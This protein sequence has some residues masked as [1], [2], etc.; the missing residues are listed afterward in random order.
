MFIKTFILKYFLN[1]SQIVLLPFFIKNQVVIIDYLFVVD[2]EA[3]ILDGA[4]LNLTILWWTF[5]I[6]TR[7]RALVLRVSISKG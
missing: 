4:Y 7:L 5:L 3:R 2:N 1:L 6:K